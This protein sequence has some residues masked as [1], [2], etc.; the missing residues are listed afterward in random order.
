ME[1]LQNL[2]SQRP[3]LKL[4]YIQLVEANGIA[5]GDAIKSDFERWPSSRLLLLFSLPAAFMGLLLGF[6][7]TSGSSPSSIRG[8]DA[9]QEYFDPP[10]NRFLSEAQCE[11]TYPTLN[12]EAERAAH[13]W[14]TSKNGITEHDLQAAQDAATDQGARVL[15][16]NNR[17]S[18]KGSVAAH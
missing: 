10:M 12:K 14:M 8:R 4:P 2:F 3:K 18:A 16:I 1:Y 5:N 9:V 15:I 17:V 11:L 6:M 7:M 13:Y